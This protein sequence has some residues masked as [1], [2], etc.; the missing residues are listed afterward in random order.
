MSKGNSLMQPNG[1]VLATY[2]SCEDC[3]TW[4]DDGLAVAGGQNVYIVNKAFNKSQASSQ[5]YTKW[6]TIAIRTDQFNQADW[7]EQ[8]LATLCHLSVGEE[9]SESVVVGLSWSPPGLGIHRRSVLAVLTSNLVLSIWETDGS[10]R[11]W[12]RTSILNQHLPP[13][14]SNDDLDNRTGRARHHLRIRAFAWSAPLL[15]SPNTRWGKHLLAVVDDDSNLTCFSISKKA[16]EGYGRWSIIPMCTTSLASLAPQLETSPR[17]TKLQRTIMERAPLKRIVVGPWQTR[18]DRPHTD[19]LQYMARSSIICVTSLGREVPELTIEVTPAPEGMTARI[20]PSS[21][22]SAQNPTQSRQNEQHTHKNLQEDGTVYSATGKLGW[23]EALDRV[24]AGFDRQNHLNGLFRVRFWGSAKSPD[25]QVEAACITLHPWDTYEY[26]SAV[27]EKCHIVLRSLCPSPEQPADH[28]KGENEV[29]LSVLANVIQ[30]LDSRDIRYSTLDRKLLQA[31]TAWAS[32]HP[33]QTE[34][35][36]RLEEKVTEQQRGPTVAENSA[37]DVQASRAQ[38]PDGQDAGFCP[39]SADLCNIC[40]S[41]IPITATACEAGH[42]FSR[43]SLS[44]L[45]IQEPGISKYCAVCERQFLD[46]SKLGP[47][48]SQSLLVRL[49]DALD[50]CP[51]CSGKYRG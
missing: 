46:I 34:T 5:D 15:A 47:Q 11:G 39:T 50:T 33:E 38:T 17:M 36:R 30:L 32:L 20:I 26:T 43:C 21:S 16:N 1:V 41:R 27:H 28:L 51:Y 19:R 8:D 18:Y 23:H 13:Y 7:P 45:S 14:N 22:L 48:D 29:L 44:L 35:C 31:Y 24:C 12:Q 2:P 3:L 4:S 37:D 42:P 40:G 9:Q 49:F 6:S 25:D 10:Q